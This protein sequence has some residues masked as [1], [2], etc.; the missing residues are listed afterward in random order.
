MIVGPIVTAPI[1]ALTTTV[2][3]AYATAKAVVAKETEALTRWCQYWLVLALISLMMPVFDMVL[4]VLP[5]YYEAKIAIAVWLVADKFQ[6]A[7]FLWQKLEPHLVA[8]QD[9]IDAKIDFLLARAKNFQVEDVRAL[10]EWAQGAVGAA[11]A[12][13]PSGVAAA[14]A[15]AK[16]SVEK[17]AEQDDKPQEPEEIVD[18]SEVADA[19]DKKEQ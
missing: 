13:V 16:K 1:I 11:G 9:T 17:A 18:A 4:P 6:G 19:E 3:P 7:T 5:L 15:A 2:Y 8:H 14:K 10:A 12:S